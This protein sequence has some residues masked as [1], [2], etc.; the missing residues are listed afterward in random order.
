MQR[1]LSLILLVVAAM[2]L[3]GCDFFL[4]P[5]ARV[6]RANERIAANDYRGAMIE[7]KNALQ[8]EPQHVTARLKLAEVA[9]QLGDAPAAEKDLRRAIDLGAD[10][11]ATAELM[12]RIRL[13]M[14]QFRDL[15]VQ[16]DAGELVLPDAARSFY[17]GQAL[18]GLQQSEA[19]IAAF[20]SVPEAD[21]HSIAARIGIAEA[22]TG[23]GKSNLAL[24]ALDELIAQ[25]PG[26]PGAWLIRGAIRAKRGEFQ[27]AQQDLQEAKSRADATLTANQFLN[28]LT[29]LSEVQLALG[30]TDAATAT[31]GQL[32]RIAPGAVGTRVLAARIA[33][34]KQDYATAVAELQRTVTAAPDFVTARFLL[35]AAL[36][37]QGNL[38]QAEL[39]LAQALQRAPEN[40]EARKLL[41][42]VRLRLG[43]PEAAMQVLLPVQQAEANDAQ[44][45]LL[46]GLA[47]LQQGDQSTGI[48]HLERAAAAQPDNQNLKLD[49]ASA[50]LKAGQNDKALDLLS[51]MDRN[52]A[53]MRQT[54]LWIAALAAA[55]DPRVAQQEVERLVNERPRDGA[56]LNLAAAFYARERQFDKARSVSQRALDLEANN[57]PAT[58]TRA[59][60]EIAAGEPDAARQWLEKAVNLGPGNEIARTALAELAIRRGDA[61]AAIATLEELRKRN[62]QAV[63]ARLRLAALYFQQRNAKAAGDVV[64]EI[65]ALGKERPEVLNALGLLFLDTGRYE[66]ALSRFQTATALDNANPAYWFNTA[67]AQ[68]S[69]GNN[70]VA[71]EALDK[72][73]ALQPNW[74]A[75]AGMLTMLDVKENKG[76]AALARIEQLKAARPRDAAV[77][78]LE[79]DVQ[80]ALKDFGKAVAAY[81]AAAAVR[82]SGPIAIKAYRA[83]QL[84]GLAN[85]VQPLEAWLVKQ[86][87]DATVRVAL[88]EAYQQT[89]DKR[90]A[91]AQYEVLER[92]GG[93]GPIALNNLA[94]LYFELGDPRAEPVAKRA[95]DGARGVAAVADTYGWILVQADKPGEALDLLKQ[96]AA[97]GDPNIEYHYAV[98]LVRSG[99]VEEGRRRLTA[100]LDRSTDF[101]AA[102]DARKLLE[103]LAG[104]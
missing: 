67:R 64:S 32:A 33:M 14:G 97:S 70:S 24:A 84:G 56:A 62:E 69:L 66:E 102:A 92:A 57:L 71:R 73:L 47:H 50:Y 80:T 21:A 61:K 51:R 30:D 20:Q 44:L 2:S 41:A 53:D 42:Q 58:L 35:G 10:P 23:Q 87:E 85:P 15:L 79:G 29:A 95:Y 6:A 76:P 3:A 25:Q 43:R 99:A 49:L 90:R 100:L 16:I 86:P 52:K 31:Q 12:A 13:A 72:A 45:D 9:L 63:D 22:L 28:L 17:R 89:G 83:R 54:S 60:I 98:A 68:I 27:L 26:A 93:A 88:A 40:M 37:A 11:A 82:A 46:M 38:Q 1:K 91:A 5:D 48:A 103:S 96:A 101:E 59:R 55:K 75:A 39:H 78:T 77:L 19:A 104:G 94:W 7:L 34:S 18:L 74:I 65:L 81:D 8:D 4:S 36:L